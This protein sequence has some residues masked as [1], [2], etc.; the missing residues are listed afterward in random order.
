MFKFSFVDL[1]KLEAIYWK[2]VK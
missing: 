2:L 1:L